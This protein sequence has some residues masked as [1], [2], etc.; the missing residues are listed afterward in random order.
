MKDIFDY[1]KYSHRSPFQTDKNMQTDYHIV[2]RKMYDK[3][4][5]KMLRVSGLVVPAFSPF[6]ARQIVQRR[7]HPD[8]KIHSVRKWK[9][10]PKS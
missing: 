1:P 10:N 6:E 9:S 2:F 4:Q 7:I 8:V 3:T 5:H